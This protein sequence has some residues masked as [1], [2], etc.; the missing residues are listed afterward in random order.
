[1]KRVWRF[2]FVDSARAF[3]SL[4]LLLLLLLTIVPAKDHFRQWRGYQSKYLQLIRGRSD[5][6]SLNRRFDRGVQQ[7]WL[8][9]L[10]VVDRCTTCHTGLTRKRA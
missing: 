7:I 4:S 6:T 8:P 3:G 10:N 9:E 1:M 5:A 2:L